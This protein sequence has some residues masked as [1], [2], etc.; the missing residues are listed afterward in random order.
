[1]PYM[2]ILIPDV[3]VDKSLRIDIGNQILLKELLKRVEHQGPITM[4]RSEF[5]AGLIAGICFV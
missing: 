4:H 2:N 1:M 5:R 3:Q